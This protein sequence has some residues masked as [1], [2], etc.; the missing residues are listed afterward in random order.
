MF[1]YEV[2]PLKIIRQDCS[3][4]TYQYSSPLELGQIVLISVG[5]KDQLGIVI[6]KTKKPTFKTKPI[7]KIVDIPRLPG[8]LIKLANWL[9][10]YYACHLSLAL[11]LMVPRGLEKKRKDKYHQIEPTH[12]QRTNILLNDEQNQVIETIRKNQPGTFLL[13]G[14][15]GSGKTEVYIRLAEEAIKNNKSV[16]ILTPEISLTPQLLSEFSDKFNNIIVT[17]SEMTESSRHLAWLEALNSKKPRIIIGPRSA[18]FMPL[19]K[20]GLIIVDEA[21]EP[22]YK[23]DQSPRY[24][25]LRVATM[26]GRYHQAIVLLGSATPD[27]ID[28]YLAN[29]SDRPILSL[30]KTARI[31][32]LPPK[33]SLIDS[34]DKKNFKKHRFMSDKLIEA[35]EKSLKSGEQSLIFHNRRGSA[36]SAICSECGWVNQCS[37]CFVP[38]HLHTDS[39]NL[40]CHICGYQADLINSCPICH[41]ASIIYKGIGTKLIED[42]LRKI[43]PKARIARFDADNNK[44]EKINNNYDELY[45]G[46]IDIIIGTQIIAKGLDLPKLQTV[47]IIQADTGLA[48]PDFNSDER[49][50]QLI[51]QVIGRVG[52]DK[53][54]TNVIVQTY[55]PEHSS[56]RYGL[57]SNYSSFYKSTIEQ[58]RKGRFPPFRYML[59]ITCSYKNEGLTIKHAKKLVADLKNNFKNN[60]LTIIGPAPAFYEKRFDK[61]R[62]QILVKS[63]NRGDLIKI[64]RSIPKNNWQTE[65]DPDGLI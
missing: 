34:K 43:F 17:H 61:F 12:R 26:L 1:Y 53:R 44:S 58:R 22:S 57:E 11:Q 50:F 41:E 40:K 29:N 55:Q 56:I 5:H 23:Q 36:G 52:R 27:I 63:K 42:E 60:D 3:F 7:I 2:A 64:A 20:I 37:N 48:L 38:L 31:D 10:E 39:S 54:K 33:I 13:H 28:Y 16:I 51:N 15:T 9:A 45:K 21:H 19:N 59:K 35:I 18:L 4:F 25:A 14:V 6:K 24:S 32:S 49:I 46:E 65:L 47:G 30:T 8:Q 62:W